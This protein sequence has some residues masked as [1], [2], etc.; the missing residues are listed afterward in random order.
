[1]F[2]HPFETIILSY[3]HNSFEADVY[4]MNATRYYILRFQ[5]KPTIHLFQSINRLG[6]SQWFTMP[7]GYC[8]EADEIGKLIEDY[9]K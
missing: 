5:N 7:G 6:E 2:V 4:Q 8:K 3:N 1:M 9:Y